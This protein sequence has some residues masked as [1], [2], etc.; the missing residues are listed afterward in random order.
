MCQTR[1]PLLLKT[2]EMC[3]LQSREIIETE[4]PVKQSS[5]LPKKYE[6]QNIKIARQN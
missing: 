6:Q 1:H 3:E 5:L 2:R 4:M